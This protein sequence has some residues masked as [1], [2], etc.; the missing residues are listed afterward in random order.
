MDT[1]KYTHCGYEEMGEGIFKG[2]GGLILQDLFLY[3]V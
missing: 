2:H 1:N 3:L